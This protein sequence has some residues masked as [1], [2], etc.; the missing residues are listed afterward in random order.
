[1]APALDT[2]VL[3]ERLDSACAQGEVMGASLSLRWS[4]GDIDI[5]AGLAHAPEDVATTPDTIFHIGSVTKCFTAEL[6]WRA[7]RAGRLDLTTPID[8]IAPELSGIRGIG[9]A[10]I[11]LAHLL[12][13][14]SGID[15]DIM[16]DAGANPGV[17]RQLI[18]SVDKV[19]TLFAPGSHLSYAN[20]G[21]ALIGRLVELAEGKHYAALLTD[22]LSNVY[23]LREFALAPEDKHR[24]RLAIAHYRAPNGALL[25]DLPGPYSNIASGTILAMSPRELTAWGA[26]QGSAISDTISAASGM[27]RVAAPTP[28]SHRYAAWG[29]GFMI[30]SSQHPRVFGHDGGT[31]GTSTFLRIHADEGLTYALAATGPGAARLFRILQQDIAALTG[32]SRS[33][34]NTL[35]AASCDD[36]DL[37]KYVGHYQR[38]GMSFR[39]ERAGDGLRLSVGGPYGPEALNNL[40]LR[41]RTQSVFEADVPALGA[42]VWLSFHDF[43]DTGRPAL[44]FAAER[45]ARRQD[46]Q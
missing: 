27:A 6:A 42:P 10:Q 15:G 45:M 46:E 17:L 34:P 14:I 40:V 36:L 8:E 13:H 3:A 29:Y 38:N 2:R 18:A 39:L 5:A 31:A 43:D 16:L 35:D 9:G 4:G 20:F 23:N 33:A 41:P 28:F 12:G 30:F 22:L 19:D 25:A 24:H 1:M 7:I 21:Y 11:T 37:D 44:F 26:A 32:V